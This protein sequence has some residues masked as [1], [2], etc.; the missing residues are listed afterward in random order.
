VEVA[1][2]KAWKHLPDRA[3][4]PAPITAD[5]LLRRVRLVAELAGTQVQDVEKAVA[6]RA[7]LRP[8]G[9]ALQQVAVLTEAVDILGDE[10]TSLL[11]GLGRVGGAQ[12]GWGG[13]MRHGRFLR[14]FFLSSGGCLSLLP[15]VEKIYGYRQIRPRSKTPVLALPTPP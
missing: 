5:E 7:A 8:I 13:R 11:A 4:G 14:W 6:K 10:G 12:V 3:A 1:G 9:P 2:Q 15:L